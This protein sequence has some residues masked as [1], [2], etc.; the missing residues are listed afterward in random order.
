MATLEISLEGPGSIGGW[1]AGPVTFG[2]RV[3]S[4]GAQ[5]SMPPSY[6]DRHQEQSAYIHINW[7]QLLDD[8]IYDMGHHG[9]LGM[10]ME[11]VWTCPK[12]G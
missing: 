11:H 10:N 12:F 7:V 8:A 1:H 6:P 5:D 4:P 9:S 3:C 2:G